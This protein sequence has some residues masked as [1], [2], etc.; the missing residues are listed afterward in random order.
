MKN[1]Y[2]AI[3]AG[4]SGSRL[5][6]VS[7]GNYP[8]QF[9][10]LEGEGTA[11]F[12]QKTFRRNSF[13]ENQATILTNESLKFLTKNQLNEIEADFE[14]ILE[15][16]RKDSFA[17]VLIACLNIYQKNAEGLVLLTPADHIIEDLQAY[18][19]TIEKGALLA[20]KGSLVTFG[21]KPNSPNVGYGYIEKG[22]ILE[23]IGFKVK[24]FHEKPNLGTAEQYLQSGNFL[25]NSGIFLFSAKDFIVEAEKYMPDS[26]LLAKDSLNVAKDQEGFIALESASFS[27]MEKISVDYA[28]LEKSDN[29]AMVESDFAWHD[30]GSWESVAEIEEKDE[31]NNRNLGENTIFEDSKN[32]F[33]KSDS[34]KLIATI[35]V[36]N[37]AIINTDDALLITDLKQTQK[38]KILAEKLQ[39][40]NRVEATEHTKTHRPW[41]FYKII[42]EGKNYK[43]K[44]IV[45]YPGQKISLQYHNKRA[46]HWIIVEGVAKITIGTDIR[47]LE[48]NQ[49]VY[50]PKT[51]KHRI[52]N[53]GESDLRFIEVQTGAYL[54]EDDIVR[55]SDDYKR[56]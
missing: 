42:D 34:K 22:E 18:Q 45:V 13:I 30:I 51:V 27:Q 43:S 46:E 9:M 14:I 55:I 54:E 6:P 2:L 33:V 32:I 48:A 38:V 20:E 36:E 29:I 8:K 16:T 21:I 52:E 44:Q 4:G 23:N 49:S 41:G 31:N 3:L 40:A 28:I 50:V 7:R 24:E 10:R 5:W 56:E 47:I 15:P 53:I 12:L 39:K 11:S 19:A 1:L 35:G 17:A 25:W 37:L 26:V